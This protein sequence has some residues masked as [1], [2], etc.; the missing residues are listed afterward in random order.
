M[1][2]NILA[3]LLLD[4]YKSSHRLQYSPN[5]E[6]VYSTWT[7]R[8]SRLSGV[9]EV[10]VF[11]IQA[12]IE[13]YLV[14]TFDRTFFN[15]PKLEVLHEIKRIMSN[16]TGDTDISHWEDLH[17]LGYLPLEIRALPEG[18]LCPIRVPM[19]T[20]ENTIPRFYWLANFIET[21]FSTEVWKPMTSAT[22]A[23]QYRKILDKYAE[24]TC[25]NNDH[26]DFQGHD[27]SFRG[28]AGVD[29]GLSSAAGHLTCFRGSDT[30]PA[31][32]WIEKYYQSVNSKGSI[33][34]SIPATEHSVAE[35]NIIEIQ[36]MLESGDYSEDIRQ[37][38]DECLLGTTFDSRESAEILYLN[39]LLNVYKSGFFSYVADTYNLWDVCSEILPVLKDKIMN[40]DG[41]VVIR[42]DSGDPADIICGINTKTFFDDYRGVEKPEKLLT[43]EDSPYFNQ[44]NKGVVE[45][46]WDTFGGTVN[47]KGYKVLDT[48]IGCIYGDAITLE[49]AE[50]ICKRLE[51]KG[52][53][54]SNIVLGIGSYTYNMNTRDTFGFALKTTYGVVG[55]KELLL[56]KDPITDDGTKKSQKGRVIVTRDE[57]GK[58]TYIDHLYKSEWEDAVYSGKDLMR[59][60]FCDGRVTNRYSWYDIRSTL[61]E[62][63]NKEIV[64]V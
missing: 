37:S 53:A 61:I 4:S 59:T 11:G 56:Y 6:Y 13:D 58:L 62:H 36:E 39:R 63:Q 45:L 21:I 44:I 5:T 60:I 25:D 28:M 38:M 19:A 51:S 46:L 30:I 43:K 40:R 10:V 50:E 15:R 17:D 57:N 54:S 1:N 49:R 27:F 35:T 42:P 29:G 7:P 20:I 24:L 23:L 14:E 55:G 18:T 22:I 16:Y 41:R 9:D 33:A 47:S 48:H 34:C 52:F 8:K 12:F 32:L 26:V 31:V 2:T 3:P 64:N